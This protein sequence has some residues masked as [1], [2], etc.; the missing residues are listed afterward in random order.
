MKITMVM[1][2]PQGYRTPN[3]KQ[4]ATS[5]DLYNTVRDACDQ[6]D[7]ECFFAIML[8]QRHKILSIE[9]VSMGSLT[10]SLVH[11]RE[12]FRPAIRE[13][14]AAIAFAHNHPSGDPTPSPEDMSLTKRLRDAGD[15]LGIRVVDHVVIGDGR[16]VS[17][18]DEGLMR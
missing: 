3:R 5:R 14:A 6:A 18:S 13:G 9:L 8:D 10:A 7:R 4:V 2:K 15:I 1:E 12:V 11:P 17:F 16:Y